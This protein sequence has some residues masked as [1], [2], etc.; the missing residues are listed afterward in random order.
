MCEERSRGV[1]RDRGHPA[2]IKEGG[3]GGGEGLHDAEAEGAVGERLAASANA[4][5][6]LLVLTKER[7]EEFDLRDGDGAVAED[8]VE[9]AKGGIAVGLHAF[10]VVAD[11]LKVVHVVPYGHLAVADEGELADFAG[12]EPRGVDV[13]DDAA[14]V[15]EGEKANVFDAGP[16]ESPPSGGNFKGLG[17]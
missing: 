1:V 17:I 15:V 9:L 5:D 12:V 8:H 2:A 4:V 3:A 13:A 10:V 11:G 6:E 7:F 16:E 14:G